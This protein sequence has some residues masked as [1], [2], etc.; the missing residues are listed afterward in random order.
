VVRVADEVWSHWQALVDERS[1]P[2]VLML[3]RRA[4]DPA[5]AVGAVRKSV[6]ET[7]APRRT[8]WTVR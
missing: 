1:V 4:G 6:S 3:F 5:G 8:I 7:L 2:S